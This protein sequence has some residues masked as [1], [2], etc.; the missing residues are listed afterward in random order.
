[1]IDSDSAAHSATG[2]NSR[3]TRRY[4]RDQCDE[5]WLQCQLA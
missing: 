2:R 4:G 1:M 3:S 5:Y